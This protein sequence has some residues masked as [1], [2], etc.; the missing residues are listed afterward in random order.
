[1]KIFNVSLRVV[2]MQIA[3]IPDN[4]HTPEPPASEKFTDDPLDKQEKLLN[5]YMDRV[6]RIQRGPVA[7]FPGLGVEQQDGASFS[8]NV[9]IAAETYDDLAVVLKQFAD[10]AG[11]LRAVP[12]GLLTDAAADPTLTPFPGMR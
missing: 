1:M 12:D 8:K 11:K 2:I 7:V 9:K 5:K 10:T 6:E 3:E 4:P